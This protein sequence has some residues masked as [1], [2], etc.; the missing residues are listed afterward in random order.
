MGWQWERLPGVST[1]CR[2]LKG[3]QRGVL[4]VTVFQV[5]VNGVGEGAGVQRV[6]VSKWR[7][8]HGVSGY[9]R[10]IPREGKVSERTHVYYFRKW[11]TYVK[12]N[13]KCIYRKKG[14]KKKSR[15]K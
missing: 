12:E 3:L 4:L 5:R 7:R 1:D 11:T 2:N 14:R 15:V 9:L 10:K 13:F 6:C 8:R